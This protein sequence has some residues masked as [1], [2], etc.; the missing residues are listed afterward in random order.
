MG[1]NHPKAADKFLKG[2]DGGAPVKVNLKGDG[3]EQWETDTAWSDLW[4]LFEVC[5]WLSSR[6]SQW[7]LLFATSLKEMLPPL[8]RLGLP[9]Q[10]E[11]AVFVS[12]DA[13]TTVI[14]AIDWKFG[15]AFRE[16]YANLK[17]YGF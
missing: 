16:K 3:S 9:G 17:P 1:G 8:E 14:G 4:E 10:W 7:D 15:Y 6:T 2:V 13:T 12:S 5:R 11:E